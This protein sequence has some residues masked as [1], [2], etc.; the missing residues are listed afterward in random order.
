MSIVLSASPWNSSGTRKRISKLNSKKTLKQPV[1][2][3]DDASDTNSEQNDGLGLE[4]FKETMEENLTRNNRVNELLNKITDAGGGLADFKPTTSRQTVSLADLMPSKTLSPEKKEGFVSNVRPN[5]VGDSHVSSYDR[6]YDPKQA[7]ILQS[8]KPYYANQIQTQGNDKLNHIIRI[9]E[10]LQM[11][12]TSNI[13]EEL[14]LYSF[15]GVF[16][17]FIVDSFAKAGKYYR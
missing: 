15:L 5:S 13:T 2:E 17:I 1:E 12:K 14:V 8:D 3:P 10:E 16:M 9:L 7:S 11:E 6:L 4:N